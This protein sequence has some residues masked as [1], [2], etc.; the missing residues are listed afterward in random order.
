MLSSTDVVK[1]YI[2]IAGA[3]QTIDKTI[4]GQLN[5]QN[6]EIAKIAE[7]HMDELIKTDTI[8]NVNPFL[9][10]LFAPQNQKFLKHW[11]Q[12]DPVEEIKKI[13]IP[14]LIL[15]GKSDLQVNIVD[16]KNLKNAKPTAQLQIIPKM[17][18]V[19]KEV[20]SVEEN[21]KSYWDKDFPLSKELVG[22]IETFIKN[23]D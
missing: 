6:P 12:I 10:Q 20:N 16:A 4:I 8:T 13:D 2:S 5:N 3:G 11:I 23:I 21:Q 18:H 22:H 9:L 7:Q 19:L 14:I 15:N 1:S 17:N